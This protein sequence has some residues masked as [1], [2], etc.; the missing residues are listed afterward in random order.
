VSHAELVFLCAMGAV[1]AP[2]ASAQPAQPFEIAPVFASLEGTWEGSGVLLGR[3]AVFE[4]R[5][6][7]ESPS[8]ARLSFSNAWMDEEGART[9]VLTSRAVYFVRGD[10]ALGVWLDD[11]PQRISLEAVLTDSTLVT[12]WSAESERGRTEYVV[13]SATMVVVR[14]FV[15]ADGAERLFAEAT[16]EPVKTDP[17]R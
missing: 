17:A 10:S 3:P 7:S 12:S 2:P 6:E 8:F 13:Q 9:P 16:Y 11:R 15:I 14:D 4:M 5:W 1:I